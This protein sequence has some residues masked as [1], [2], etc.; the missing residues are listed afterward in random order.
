VLAEVRDDQ[1]GV[2][3]PAGTLI[4]RSDDDVR[5]WNWARFRANITLATVDV[6]RVAASDA[7]AACASAVSS[8]SRLR[9][10]I[11]ST[12]VTVSR[13]LR[14]VLAD[15]PSR[16][17]ASQSSAASDG[18]RLRLAVARL[19]VGVQVSELVPYFGLGL[20]AHFAA[21]SPAARAVPSETTP[22]LAAR[23]QNLRHEHKT[24]C[25]LPFALAV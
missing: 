17:W 15:R 5:W 19:D 3:H 18:H 22:R 12:A 23:T 10:M 13:F 9:P 7:S 8:R 24:S 25:P 16:P 6:L 11:A 4:R 20:A 14:V 21:D 2:V 1:R